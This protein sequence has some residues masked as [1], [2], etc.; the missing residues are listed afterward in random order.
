MVLSENIKAIFRNKNHEALINLIYT[1]NI[2]NYKIDEEIKKSGLSHA[3]YNVLRVLRKHK[4]EETNLNFLKQRML[5]KS[6]D[7]S[8]IVDRLFQKGYLTRVENKNDRRAKSL[9][10]TNEGL[11][12]LKK[13]DKVKTLEDKLLSK[14]DENEVDNL[15]E[16][17][18]KIQ[19]SV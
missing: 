10:I 2:L 6:S 9:K 18:T 4:G 15:L 13:S 8:R 16:L 1:S 5:D 19:K 11:K 14:L 17:L 3:Q 7:I 12:A